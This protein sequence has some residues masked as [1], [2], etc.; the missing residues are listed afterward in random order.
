[1]IK[2]VCPVPAHPSGG[3]MFIHRW[4]ELLN[5]LG[6]ES[7]VFQL[8]PFSVWWDS[9]EYPPSLFSKSITRDDTL[10]VPECL[11]GSIGGPNDILLLQNYIWLTGE[12]LPNTSVMVCSFFLQKYVWDKFGVRAMVVRP[13]LSGLPFV[14]GKVPDPNKV[15][16]VNRKSDL[17]RRVAYLA[18]LAGFTVDLIDKDL[19]QADLSQ[20]M[21]SACYYVHVNTPEGWNQSALEAMACG[22]IVVGT[23]GGGGEEYMRSYSN[24]ILSDDPEFCGISPDA[25]IDNI[26]S[27]LEEA[28]SLSSLRYRLMNGGLKTVEQYTETIT[29]R[30]MELVKEK[31]WFNAA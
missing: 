22:C 20:R 9:H 15:L 1:M 14:P 11:W 5:T 28:R 27:G 24:C 23:H 21:Q 12:I 7:K 17:N 8:S 25:F 6:V 26:I 30:E 29:L 16:I 4:A 31:G 2:W 13:Y 19:T 3:V 10:V 18:D